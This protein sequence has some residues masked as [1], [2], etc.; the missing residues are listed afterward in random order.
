MG[1]DTGISWTDHTQNFWRGCTKV[2]SGCKNCYMFRDQKRYGNDPTK[3]VRAAGPTFMSPLKWKEEARVFTCSYS[4]FFIEEADEWRDDAWAIIRQTKNL[5][6]QILTKRPE[7][8]A[9]RLP[10][11]WPLPNVWLGI[12]AEDQENLD[13]RMRIFGAIPAVVKF[14]SLEPLLEKITFHRKGVVMPNNMLALLDWLVVGGE[15]GPDARKMEEG[16]AI[17]IR[18]ECRAA[19]VPYFFKQHGG[20]RKI[21]GEWGGNKLDGEV[22]HEM[23][24]PGLMKKRYEELLADQEPLPEPEEEDEK[25]SLDKDE[26]KDILEQ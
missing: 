25:E 19:G 16:W 17:K 5:T 24:D 1:R 13:S 8:I 20:Y 10:E 11:D 22:Y 26:T 2:S 21:D 15:S 9:G 23:P 4:D 12:S 14:I 7:N 3:V 18:D 6:Y